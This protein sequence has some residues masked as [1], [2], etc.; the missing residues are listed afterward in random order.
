VHER[1]RGWLIFFVCAI[2]ALPSVFLLWNPGGFV[3]GRRIIAKKAPFYGLEN[4][5]LAR[6]I[7]SPYYLYVL[8][9]VIF[10]E[11]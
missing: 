3:S 8:A 5:R 6:S 2:D 11:I 9:A 4:M 1:V 7:R 10:L